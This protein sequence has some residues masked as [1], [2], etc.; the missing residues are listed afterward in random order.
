MVPASVLTYRAKSLLCMLALLIV[1]DVGILSLLKFANHTCHL[2]TRRHPASQCCGVLC[3]PTVPPS[4]VTQA[5][6]C[7]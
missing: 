7:S 1:P 3:Q 4:L 2:R 5:L 6:F